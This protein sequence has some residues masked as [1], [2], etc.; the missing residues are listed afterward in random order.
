MPWSQAKQA[1]E[2]QT[3]HE[4]P[5]ILTS[6]TNGKKHNPVDFIEETS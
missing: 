3:Y 4:K 2:I 6:E 1:R 5:P